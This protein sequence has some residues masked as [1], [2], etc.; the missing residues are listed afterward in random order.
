MQA[1]IFDFDGVFTDNK[2]Y[3]FEDGREAVVCNRGDGLGISM[4]KKTGV[5]MCV[6]S[7]ETNSVVSV[8]CK[9]LGLECF[10]GIG[11]KLSVL[12]KWLNEKKIDI[13]NAAFVG[14]DINDLACLMSV[15][16]SI[17]P[18]DAHIEVKCIA[19]IELKS[20]G[21]NGAVREVAEMYLK[22]KLFGE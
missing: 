10:Q 3:V 9:K 8:R 2:V 22:N 5:S 6:I 15:G 11:D 4:L 16:L 20:H 19:K 18:A 17:V 14:N 21:G 13:R 1:I 12:K 7:T